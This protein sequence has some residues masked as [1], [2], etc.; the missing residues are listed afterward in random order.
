[1]T[2]SNKTIHKLSQAL[3]PEVAEKIFESERWVDLMHEMVP[4]IIQAE[5]GEI[6][7]DLLLEISMVVMDKIWLKV[8]N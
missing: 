4:E 1:M 8:G 7:E 5:M 3:A 6:E 2:L